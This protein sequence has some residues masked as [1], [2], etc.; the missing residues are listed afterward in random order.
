MELAIPVEK[1]IL[2]LI[3]HGAKVLEVGCGGGHLAQHIAKIRSD[4]SLCGV[5]LSPEQIRRAEK[6]CSA[7]K[8]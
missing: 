3:Q 1:L 2:N 6:R 4:V 5:D 8:D 7:W